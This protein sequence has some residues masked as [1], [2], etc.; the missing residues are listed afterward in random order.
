MFDNVSKLI[1]YFKAGGLFAKIKPGDKVIEVPESVVTDITTGTFL[2]LAYTALTSVGSIF[3]RSAAGF[4][5]QII[6]FAIGAAITIAIMMWLTGKLG[7]ATR[8]ATVYYVLALL[9]MLALTLGT[10]SLLSSALLLMSFWF[11]AGLI[12]LIAI[13]VYFLAMVNYTVGCIDFC[14]EANKE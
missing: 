9:G 13:P 8:K 11:I 4:F 14:I 5:S 12:H 2:S 6:S 7:T 10:L 3:N 1:G